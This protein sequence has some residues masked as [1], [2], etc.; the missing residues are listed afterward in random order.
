[1]AFVVDN[2]VVMGWLIERRATAYTKRVLI[3]A[4]R[5]AVHASA[6]WPFELS[7]A[8]FMLQRRALI[9]ADEADAVLAQAR[10][11]DI[12]VD[13]EPAAPRVLLDWS[14]RSALT[15]YD[16]SYVE[17]AARHGWPLATLDGP[18]QRAAQRLGIALA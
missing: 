7:N 10:R 18:I 13:A 1:V 2:S 16:A 3:R 4:E 12:I 6:V 14:R 17:L 15:S 9:R 8:L 5:E 11:L